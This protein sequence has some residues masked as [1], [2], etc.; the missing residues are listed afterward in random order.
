MHAMG[1]PVHMYI[2]TYMHAHK[3]K[4]NECIRTGAPTEIL[5]DRDSLQSSN[6][7]R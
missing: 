6:L 7:I 5:M 3:T 1:S 2:H 4:K